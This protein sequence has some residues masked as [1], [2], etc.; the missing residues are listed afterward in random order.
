MPV[1]GHGGLQGC[2]TSSFPHCLDS[3]LFGCQPYAQA[4][5]FSQEYSWYSFLLETE[6]TQNWIKFQ[7]FM[8]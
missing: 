1:T 7:P 2:E 8:V 3:R 5:L 6:S 4:T